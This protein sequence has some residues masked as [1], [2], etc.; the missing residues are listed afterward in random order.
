[1]VETKLSIKVLDVNDN[2]P[3]FDG[4]QDTFIVKEEE[5]AKTFVGKVHVSIEGCFEVVCMTV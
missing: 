1:M 5:P 2:D 3:I 4:S